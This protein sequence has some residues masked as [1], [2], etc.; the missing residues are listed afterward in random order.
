MVG[1][2]EM[3]A[4]W[5]V[6]LGCMNSGSMSVEPSLEC[7]PGF[8]DILDLTNSASDE[9]Y[10]ISGGTSY[11]AL[12]MVRK[13]GGVASES[14]PLVNMYITYDASVA[15]AF[16][17]AMLYGRRMVSEGGDLSTNEEILQVAG[18][19]VC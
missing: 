18:A 8:P 7:C 12:G 5:S 13:A 10:D 15:S 1:K 2:V 17:G 14:V 11:V 19:S 4:D 9:I 16:E 6:K 3:M